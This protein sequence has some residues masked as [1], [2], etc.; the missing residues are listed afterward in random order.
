MAT[1]NMKFLGRCLSH[2]TR[3]IVILLFLIFPSLACASLE[4]LGELKADDIPR[5]FTLKGETVHIF[6]VSVISNTQYR[7]LIQPVDHNKSEILG[8]IEVCPYETDICSDKALVSVR[9]KNSVTFT[10]SNN[11]DVYLL[12]SVTAIGESTPVGTCIV[13]LEKLSPSA[14]F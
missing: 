10:A 1:V 7:V 11:T 3:V 5:T 4:K 2:N 14:W 6:R 13:T 9:G 12:I 8:N